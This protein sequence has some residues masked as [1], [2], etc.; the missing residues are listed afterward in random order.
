MTT[1][2]DIFASAALRNAACTLSL[3]AQ[4]GTVLRRSS[5]LRSDEAGI[6]VTLASGDLPL[7]ESLIVGEVPVHVTIRSQEEDFLFHTFAIS[8]DPSFLGTDKRVAPALL[9]KMPDKIVNS[10]RRKTFRMPISREEGMS[11][12]IWRINEYVLLRDR[13]LPSQEMPCEPKDLGEGGMC[14]VLFPNSE[15]AL[16]LKFNQRF[17][18]ELKYGRHEMLFEARL[19]HPEQTRRDD[20]SATCGFEFIHTERDVECR[21]HRQKLQV[22][23][24]EVQRNAVKRGGA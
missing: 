24:G 12:R 18:V 15:E 19:R 13:P 4:S 6:W 8:V 16:N 17:R 14:A 1:H 7:L 23:L 22:V 9:L 20:E 5:V 3:P 11:V 21:R 2:D 10:T